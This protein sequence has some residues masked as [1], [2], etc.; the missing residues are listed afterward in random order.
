[1]VKRM[2]ILAAVAVVLICA[3]NAEARGR[4]GCPSCG[5]CPDGVCTLPAAGAK[6]AADAKQAPAA[7]QTPAPPPAEAPAVTGTPTP[8]R[9]ATVARRGWLSRRR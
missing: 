1:M 3:S 8:Q 4:R 9:A 6:S 5:G 2:M 7:A